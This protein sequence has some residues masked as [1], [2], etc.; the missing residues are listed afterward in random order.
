MEHG[1]REERR[2]RPHG[3]HARCG[4]PRPAKCGGRLSSE[5]SDLLRDCAR[6]HVL[7]RSSARCCRL[8]RPSCC[9]SPSVRA[10]ASESDY[11]VQSGGNG[12]Q[13]NWRVTG[14]GTDP[15]SRRS[16][17]LLRFRDEIVR[18]FFHRINR[19][20]SRKNQ[21]FDIDTIF[22]SPYYVKKSLRNRIF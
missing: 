4:L 6:R 12:F 8:L 1:R 9:L 3:T 18:G 11:G 7:P 14:I 21:I 10:T 13:R 22:Y 15:V 20:L 2:R 5:G 17:C 19:I 16:C